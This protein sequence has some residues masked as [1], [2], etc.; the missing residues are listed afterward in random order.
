[1]T[2][3]TLL[4]LLLSVAAVLSGCGA[5]RSPSP[6]PTQQAHVFYAAPATPPGKEPPAPRPAPAR[7]TDAAMA[8][9]GRRFARA[10][11]RWEVGHATAH[12]VRT[13]LALSTPQVAATKFDQQP[14]QPQAATAPPQAYCVTL[15]ISHE[16]Q[17]PGRVSA[18]VEIRRA[19]R[20]DQLGLAIGATPRG[21]R[22]SE[23]LAPD[24]A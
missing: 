6:T 4:P 9:V 5:T 10:Y 23:I 16:S 1:M 12:D 18:N 13:L 22:V 8:S 11:L 2:A 19:G 15:R 7:T 14:R 17:I 21:P 3:R 24:G 20:L